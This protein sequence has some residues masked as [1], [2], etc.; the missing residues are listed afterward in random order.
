MK[1]E[2]IVLSS[3]VEA[4]VLTDGEAKGSTRYSVQLYGHTGDFIPSR[5]VVTGLESEAAATQ[6][7]DKLAHNSKVSIAYVPRDVCWLRS[8]DLAFAPVK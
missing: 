6:L 3:Q 4:R 7:K 5:F 2:L 1:I 8:G